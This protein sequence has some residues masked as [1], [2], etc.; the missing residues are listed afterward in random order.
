MS[1]IVVTWSGQILDYKQ[2][3]DDEVKPSDG[4]WWLESENMKY[5]SAVGSFGVAYC[6]SL[7]QP[8]KSETTRFMAQQLIH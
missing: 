8:G 7:A 5:S 6:Y 1:Q 4:P 2:H 3:C